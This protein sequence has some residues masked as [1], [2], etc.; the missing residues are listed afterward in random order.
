M[1]ISGKL[2]DLFWLEWNADVKMLAAYCLGCNNQGKRFHDDLLNKLDCSDDSIRRKALW[3]I[4][5]FRIMTRKIL[6]KFLLCFQDPNISIRAETCTACCRLKIAEPRILKQLIAVASQDPIWKIRKLAIEDISNVDLPFASSE[7]ITGFSEA[8]LSH[9]GVWNEPVKACL[10]SA[11]HDVS[12]HTVRAQACRTLASLS[13]K[14]PEAATLLQEYFLSETDPTI[15]SE[16][17][18]ILSEV[19]PTMKKLVD[20]GKTKPEARSSPPSKNP[21]PYILPEPEG[22]ALLCSRTIPTKSVCVN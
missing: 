4:G 15:Q 10:L 14:F 9:I 22:K 3:I 13:E 1:D 18:R 11:R 2:L 12:H 7:V 16:L 5:Q 17:K 20:V 6:V 21:N 8:A 19:S